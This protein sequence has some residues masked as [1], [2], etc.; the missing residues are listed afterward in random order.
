MVIRALP[1][2]QERHPNLLYLIVGETHPHLAK[3]E[4]QAYREETATRSPAGRSPM[5]SAAGGP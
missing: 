1:Q 5:R 3:R 4:G 2:V